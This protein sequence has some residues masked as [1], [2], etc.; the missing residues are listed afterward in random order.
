MLRA[1]GFRFLNCTEIGITR[2]LTERE[3]GIITESSKRVRP[4]KLARIINRFAKRLIF[5]NL[6]MLNW[7]HSK[8]ALTFSFEMIELNANEITFCRNFKRA[9]S[10]LADEKIAVIFSKFL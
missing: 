6:F 8:Q 9:T 10:I 1:L 5:Q 7:L 4:P 2:Q 3:N